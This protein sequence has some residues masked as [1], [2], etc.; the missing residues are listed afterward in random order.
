LVGN[1]N[2]EA[3]CNPVNVGFLTGVGWKR[4]QETVNQYAVNDRRILPPSGIPLGSVQV[5]PP[6]IYLYKGELS[7]LCYP[8]D[9]AITGPYAPYDKWTDTFNTSTEFVNPQQGRSLAAMCFLMG[10]SSSLVNQP[11]KSA[12]GTITG[13]PALIAAKQPITAQMVVPGI[14]LS[15]AR[16]IWE[17]KDQQPFPTSLY[18]FSAAYSGPQ[19]VE[20]E[21]LLPDGR[22]IF[23]ATNFLASFALDVPPNSFESTTQNIGVDTRALF[24]L[25]DL[26]DTKNALPSLRLQGAAAIDNLN[27]GWMATRTGQSLHAQDLG[28]A[29]SVTFPNTSVWSA[30]TQV[31]SIEGMI[32]INALKGYNRGNATI[33]S[34]NK[35]WNASI[36]L[37]ENMYTGL[38]FRGGTQFEVS[39]AQVNNA[40][41]KNQWHHV[42]LTISP[43][44]YAV[45]VDGV[46]VTTL[47][48]NEFANWAGNGNTTITLG[49]FDGWIDEVVV[50]SS[51]TYSGNS[52]TVQTPV[53]SPAGGTIASSTPVT[54]TVAN[55]GATI[56]YTLDGSEPS[57][58]S[59]PYSGPIYLGATGL[60]KAKGYLSGSSDSATA[61]ATFTI[62][63]ATGQTAINS[64]SFVGAD[65]TVQGSWKGVYGKEGYNIIGDNA[66]YPSYVQ[67]VPSG[68][69]DYTWVTSTTAVSA[70]QKADAG[71]DRIAAVWYAANVFNA[72]F[73]FLDTS[74]HCVR[75]YFLDW[76]ASGRSQKVEVVDAVSGT[77]LD[78]QDINGFSGGTYLS[79]NV[80][81]K[82][83]FRI[84]RV[85]P[86]N[87]VL[88]GI[89]Y[90]VAAQS[91]GGGGGTVGGGTSPVSFVKIDTQNHGTWRGIYGSDGYHV[92]GTTANYPA[93]AQV[94]PSGKDDYI[95][96]DS[97]T[98]VTAPQKPSPAIDRIASCWYS[99]NTFSVDLNIVDGKTHQVAF[100][101]LDWTGTDRDQ[102]VEV[103]DAATGQVLDTRSISG[104][105]GGKYL[106]WN[107]STH[108]TVRFTKNQGPNAVVQGIFFDTAVA[109]IPLLKPS[110]DANGQMVLTLTGV[111]GQAYLIQS[112]SNLSSW[113]TISTI[114][115]VGTP[116]VLTDT[117]LP[118]NKT[119]FYRAIPA[120]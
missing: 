98:D 24:H 28:D 30:D 113:L 57:N 101:C 120:L 34:L 58:S 17:A 65:S 81:G 52:G 50:K 40:L 14:D 23:V 116:Q 15:K 61:S 95:W 77:V 82:I 80:S 89:F 83:R 11:W 87:A 112:S 97:V 26:S 1:I 56:R 76:D 48:S 37:V 94:T 67:T 6:Y 93:Y 70:L 13:L 78:S 7:A 84:T 10:R 3:G 117:I 75:L 19:W 63:G 107:I 85:G 42:K 47:A 16:I 86:Q 4:Q 88:S 62:G 108:V 31:I 109:A 33:L 46:V 74:T 8:A 43:A 41:T 68:K 119:K 110:K 60:L 66:S 32:Y 114:T 55:A 35:N 64:A 100:Y 105:S 5:G 59:I 22:R 38:T 21:A 36:E 29:A 106:V 104:F 45:A 115:S 69:D 54:M 90:D 12:A 51:A 39:G 72:D 111:T 2:Y 92:M 27:V 25:D 44:G 18:Q 53:I 103:V 9:G 71:S 99:S 102:K 79:W 49:N 96:S 73:T 91:S 20:A 118:G